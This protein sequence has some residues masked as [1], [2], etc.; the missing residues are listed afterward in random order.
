MDRILIADDEP[1]MRN[2]AAE[3]VRRLG[4][5]VV[6]AVDGADAIR[7]LEEEP[8]DLILTDLMMPYHTGLD[9]LKAAKARSPQTIVILAT[10]FGSIETAVEAMKLGAFNFLIKPF[11]PDALEAALEKAEE[12]SKLVKE[13]Q[14][15]RQ[16]Q[17]G[18]D[19][20]AASPAMRNYG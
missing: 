14:F 16:E 11:S 3:T 1:L 8:F 15:L 2:F 19:F 5:E 10:A 17:I 13:N 12:H 4:K 7:K 20:I 9:V 18:S 6:T